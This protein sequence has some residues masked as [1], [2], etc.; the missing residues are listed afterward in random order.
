MLFLLTL[1]RFE[2]TEKGKFPTYICSQWF[3]LLIIV[4][5]SYVLTVY[6]LTIITYLDY[7]IW[8]T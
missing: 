7:I 4:N 2:S 6:L 1:N 8:L 5:Y 3:K